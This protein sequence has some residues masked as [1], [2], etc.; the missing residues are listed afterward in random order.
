MSNLSLNGKGN[1]V[2]A[3]P[4][5]DVKVT[6]RWSAGWGYQDEKPFCNSCIFQSYVGFFDGVSQKGKADCLF[7]AQLPSGQKDLQGFV[8]DK[9]TAPD[10][11]GVYLITQREAPDYGCQDV[12]QTLVVR[13]HDTT[14]GRALGAILVRA[15][16]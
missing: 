5:S 12:T 7:S 4:R 2:E 16:K 14:I 1:V 3:A 8:T 10:M 11:P 13:G 6:F 9:F 15:K